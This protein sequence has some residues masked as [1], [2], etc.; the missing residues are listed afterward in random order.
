ML[1]L[2]HFLGPET[3]FYGNDGAFIESGG[4]DILRGDSCNTCHWSFPNHAGTHIDLPRHFVLD[5]KCLHDY[6]AWFWVYHETALISL[7][8][9][10]PGQ[11]L[12]PDVLGASPVSPT[13][14]LLLLRTGF[15][16]FRGTEVYW[17]DGPVFPP[18]WAEYLRRNFPKL[19]AFG[20]DAISISS[21]ADRPTGRIAHQQFLCGESPVL[22]I[23]DMDLSAVDL[24]TRFHRVT[25]APLLVTGADASP[26]TIIAEVVV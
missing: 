20:F 21:W 17:Q 11:V 9:V 6:P 23:E 22:L 12:S 2:S 4:R 18:T 3:P 16:R 15:G 13:T 7:P 26:C 8:D 24:S 14:E 1:Y 10:Q 19:R 25:V 5:G